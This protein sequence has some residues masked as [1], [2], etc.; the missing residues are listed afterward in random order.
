M[1]QEAWIFEFHH[2]QNEEAPDSFFPK[3]RSKSPRGNHGGHRDFSH[4]MKKKVL[5]KTSVD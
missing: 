2:F 1:A 4:S 3:T 5:A